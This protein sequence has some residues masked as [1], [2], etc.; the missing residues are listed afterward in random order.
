MT[1]VDVHLRDL[2]IRRYFSCPVAATLWAVGWNG[3]KRG[4]V[5]ITY[6]KGDR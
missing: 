6:G 4:L 2:H 3:C 1:Y 5:M